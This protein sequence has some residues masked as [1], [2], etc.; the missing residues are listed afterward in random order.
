MSGQRPRV[1]F[2]S[3]VIAILLVLAGVLMLFIFYW[4]ST[5]CEN[6]YTR[7]RSN[8]A[9]NSRNALSNSSDRTM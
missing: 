6:C 1:N 7:T 3:H 8:V 9:S 4:L 5:R 2:R